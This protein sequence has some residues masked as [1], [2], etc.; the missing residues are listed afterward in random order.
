ML[1]KA[2]SQLLIV[3]F[4]DD[5]GTECEREIERCDNLYIFPVDLFIPA[6]AAFIR[7]TEVKIISVAPLHSP[8]YLVV[9]E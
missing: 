3:K 5:E 2:T 7:Q 4:L 1:Q 9:T 8:H 6:L